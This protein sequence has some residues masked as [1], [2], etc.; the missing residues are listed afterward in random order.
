MTKEDEYTDS[1]RTTAGHVS[2]VRHEWSADERP[3]TAVVRAVAAATDREPTG[4]EPLQNHVDVDALDA[5]LRSG[6]TTLEM[7]FTYVGAHVSID[8]AGTIE[9]RPNADAPSRSVDQ[10]RP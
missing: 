7:S 4:L 8:N 2:P 5:L 1:E 10:F 6:K 9:V 3:S